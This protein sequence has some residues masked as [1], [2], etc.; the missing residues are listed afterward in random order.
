M[1]PEQRSQREKLFAR[2]CALC[3]ELHNNPATDQ[4][5]L[6]IMAWPDGIWCHLSD[7][8]I[9][10]YIADFPLRLS[11]DYRLIDIGTDEAIE[12]TNREDAEKLLTRDESIAMFGEP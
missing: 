1:T 6:Y 8:L 2:F 3:E 4:K 12:F 10:N 7:W 11:D 9:G 5:A